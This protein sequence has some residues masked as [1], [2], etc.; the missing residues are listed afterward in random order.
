MLSAVTS[1]PNL[2]GACRLPLAAHL[3]PADSW[4]VVASG[5]MNSTTNALRWSG[6]IGRIHSATIALGCLK[7]RYER[8]ILHFFL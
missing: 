8:T 6:C 4:K 3:R 1:S 7:G 2:Q 5:K